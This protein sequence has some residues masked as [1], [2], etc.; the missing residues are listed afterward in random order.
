MKRR[1]VECEERLKLLFSQNETKQHLNALS[2]MSSTEKN[3]LPA[4]K[5][6]SKNSRSCFSVLIRLHEKLKVSIWVAK[7][8]GYV[9]FLFEYFF[10]KSNPA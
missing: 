4:K 2:V 1:H 9:P 7:N 3:Q 5:I 8:K 10:F 6:S